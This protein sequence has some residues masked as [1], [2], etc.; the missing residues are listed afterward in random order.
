MTH[1]T[2]KVW[3][4]DAEENGERAQGTSR[5]SEER[6]NDLHYGRIITIWKAEFFQ[7]RSYEIIEKIFEKIFI[8]TRVQ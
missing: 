2:F 6:G 7:G 3:W 4:E 8:K 5:Y 1:K